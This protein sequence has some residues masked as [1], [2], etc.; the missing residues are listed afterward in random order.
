MVQIQFE[1]CKPPSC[2]NGYL[3]PSGA[4]KGKA[5]MF[6]LVLLFPLNCELVFFGVS[7]VKMQR[8]VGLGL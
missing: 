8:Y 3:V 5:N 1:A 2:K 7:T 6:V 4:G